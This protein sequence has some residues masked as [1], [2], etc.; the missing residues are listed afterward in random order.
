MAA[1]L[2]GM[3][4]ALEV[5]T[6]SMG[7]LDHCRPT[8][9]SA[10][11]PPSP[12]PPPPEQQPGTFTLAE[13]GISLSEGGAV[14]RAGAGV[15]RGRRSRGSGGGGGMVL[16]QHPEDIMRDGVHRLRL[17][18]LSGTPALGVV[19]VRTASSPQAP[20]V[21]GGAPSGCGRRGD[22]CC[23]LAQ[24]ESSDPRGSELAGWCG[25]SGM[26]EAGW[27]A[28]SPSLGTPRSRR[29]AAAPQRQ[30]RRR[31]RARE[32]P[33]GA[34]GGVC[35][36]AGDVLELALDL[37]RPQGL[38]LPHDDRQGGSG[39]THGSCSPPG[40]AGVP[41]SSSSRGEGRAGG[42]RW[43]YA[44][45][46]GTLSAYKNGR[47]LGVI[48]RAR[49]GPLCCYAELGPGDAVRLEVSQRWHSSTAAAHDDDDDDDDDDDER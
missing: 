28:L 40:W 37:R 24:V 26:V 32:A 6:A 20:C 3:L 48:A 45:G 16:A 5:R 31:Q 39:G 22:A 11:P 12:A 49:E 47:L 15:V 4:D 29:E 7:R 1:A 30:R 14:A 25:R 2:L 38:A 8:I 18:V 17:R 23:C 35:F 36:G 27:R 46:V 19:Q 33:W 21:W 42:A 34:Q 44:S 13:F 41:S 9:T 43:S 10:T